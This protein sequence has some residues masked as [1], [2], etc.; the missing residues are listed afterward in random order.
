[1]VFFYQFIHPNVITV[2]VYEDLRLI[3]ELPQLPR[4]GTRFDLRVELDTVIY[5]F[6]LPFD[7]DN[8]SAETLRLHDQFVPIYNQ[9][10]SAMRLAIIHSE[11]DS[12]IAEEFERQ[13]REFITE[14]NRI[15]S[16]IRTLEGVIRH[17]VPGYRT[18]FPVYF[19]ES[20]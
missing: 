13:A 16:L 2:P 8:V 11:I 12:S 5:S 10:R 18:P 3:L 14:A 1:M 6:N 9:F 20:D 19:F 17:F 7:L 4:A 15:S